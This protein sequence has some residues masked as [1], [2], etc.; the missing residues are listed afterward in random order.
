VVVRGK[1]AA[2]DDVNNADAVGILLGLEDIHRQ[3]HAKFPTIDHVFLAREYGSGGFERAE[4]TGD[5]R[6]DESEECFSQHDAPL[7][8]EA[9]D[10][11]AKKHTPRALILGMRSRA[12]NRL[13]F[14]V[15][16]LKMEFY[17]GCSNEKKD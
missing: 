14:A 11:G 5:E 8:E 2:A 3:R 13:D 4:R 10:L 15:D 17:D 16:G 12:D 1:P 6:E 9:E 7:I